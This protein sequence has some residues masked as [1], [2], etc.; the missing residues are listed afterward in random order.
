LNP[1]KFASKRHT[2][3]DSPPL[4]AL[5]PA[6][7][8]VTV[9]EHPGSN[10]HAQTAGRAPVARAYPVETTTG[11]NADAF[12]GDPLLRSD[13]DDPPVFTSYGVCPNIRVERNRQ[14]HARRLLGIER[15][16]HS[17]LSLEPHAGTL[18]GIRPKFRL[19]KVAD[20]PSHSQRA[21]NPKH[22][23]VEIKPVFSVPTLE[24]VAAIENVGRR[25]I[26]TTAPQGAAQ[27]LQSRSGVDSGKDRVN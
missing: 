11:P 26:L 14:W 9:E 20:D 2:R 16:A 25:P 23:G 3:G 1:R 27:V 22:S 24:I 7:N 4:F 15:H 12:R 21:S 17:N 19:P 8:D 6:P 5:R 13:S 10:Q 18:S